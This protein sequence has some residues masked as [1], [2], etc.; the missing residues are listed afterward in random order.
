[1]KMM[2]IHS[3]VFL[4]CL[5]VCECGLSP[6]QRVSITNSIKGQKEITSKLEGLLANPKGFAKFTDYSKKV[7]DLL[8][9]LSQLLVK[10]MMALAL[11][12]N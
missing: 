12:R 1:M 11:S 6:N 10:F 4:T 9:L 8:R 3:L 5:L 2:L 7:F